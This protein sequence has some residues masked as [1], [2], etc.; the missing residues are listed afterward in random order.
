MDRAKFGFKDAKK[1]PFFGPDLSV[2]L[3]RF[4]RRKALGDALLWKPQER[5]V[6]NAI[7]VGRRG[8]IAEAKRACN[9]SSLQQRWWWY[10]S[11]CCSSLKEAGERRRHCTLE[12]SATFC[13]V[14]SASACASP[15]SR[16]CFPQLC[17]SR[18]SLIFPTRSTV[19]VE[20]T[21]A[22]SYLIVQPCRR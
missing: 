18:S 12:C 6:E 19:D 5:N 16:R 1:N 8:R 22:S 3:R 17:S 9:M 10:C 11:K 20:W 15:P 13:L 4:D 2:L 21:S 7:G 14:N